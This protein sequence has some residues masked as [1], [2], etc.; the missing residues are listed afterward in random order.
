MQTLASGWRAMALEQAPISGP[1][2]DVAAELMTTGKAKPRRG[3]SKKKDVD[4]DD[5]SSGL[6]SDET[7]GEDTGWWTE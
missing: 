4:E 3:K 6:Y 2:R 1:A 5:G 7:F